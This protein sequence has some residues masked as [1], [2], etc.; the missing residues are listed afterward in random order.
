VVCEGGGWV[1]GCQGGVQAV[2]VRH[3]DGRVVGQQGRGGV[4]N[5]AYVEGLGVETLQEAVVTY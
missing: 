5:V 1:G 4:V 2:R 3:E